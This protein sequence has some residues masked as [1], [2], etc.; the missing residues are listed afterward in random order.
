T[1][2]GIVLVEAPVHD[3][4]GAGEH[5]FH[6]LFREALG[7][8]PPIDSDGAGPGYS[9]RHDRLVIVAIAVSAD[10]AAFGKSRQALRKIGDHVAAI[11]FAVDKNVHAQFFLRLNPKCGGFTFQ[12]VELIRS[13]FSFHKISAGADEVV[14][15]WKAADGGRGKERQIQNEAREFF[16]AHVGSDPLRRHGRPDFAE[17]FEFG[18]SA[19]AR[20]I[21]EAARSIEI[22]TSTVNFREKAIDL[23]GDF[24]DIF[25]FCVASINETEA[26]RLGGAKRGDE[27]DELRIV[28][29]I[30]ANHIHI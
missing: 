18:I 3:R 19:I 15:L 10:E 21:F 4:V 11:H 9:A 27:L 6:R 12:A 14:R 25:E 17:Q 7:I 24:A 22:C 23:A 29:E 8:P 28:S 13:D 20:E 5:S 1:T 2:I 26:E 30:E 16:A